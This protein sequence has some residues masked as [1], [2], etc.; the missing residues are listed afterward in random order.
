MKIALGTLIACAAVSSAA[1]ADFVGWTASSRSVAGGYLVNVFA[2][3]DTAGD[4]LLNVY[5]S[6]AQSPDA[7]YVTTNSAGGF[8]QG[9]G[10][11]GLFAPAGSQ[12]WTT[13]DSFLTIGGGLNSS[14]NWSANGNTAADPS[15][16]VSYFDTDLE[17]ATTVSAFNTASNESGFTNTFVNAIPAFAGW[18]VGGAGTG[19][20]AQTARDLSSL[21]S[22]RIASSSAAAAAGTLGI[23]V[24]QLYVAELGNGATIEWKLGATVK[25]LDGGID[26]QSFSFTIPAPGAVA[27]LGLAGLTGTRRRR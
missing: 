8:L 20:P 27:L 1:S 12:S 4:A 9:A 11:Q 15:W 21:S 17:E 24:G 26:Q 6:N 14:N 25:G 18:F 23:M 22:I 10:S 3:V 19:V 13:L 2:V 7:G 16:N 5:G